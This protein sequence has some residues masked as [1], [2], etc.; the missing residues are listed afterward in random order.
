MIPRIEIQKLCIDNGFELVELEPEIEEQDEDDL[1][2]DF[3]ETLSY[4]RI[5]QALEAN[6]WPH[7]EFVSECSRSKFQNTEEILNQNELS[8]EKVEDFEKLLSQFKDFKGNLIKF[9]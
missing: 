3:K 4:E 2:D 6:V 7:L 8:E 9:L 5:Y 1:E